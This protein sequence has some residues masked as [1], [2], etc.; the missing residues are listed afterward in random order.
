MTI[1]EAEVVQEAV[2]GQEVVK[3]KGPVVGLMG[4]VDQEV[5]SYPILPSTTLDQAGQG[6]NNNTR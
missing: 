2:V 6:L 1:Q 3:C 4:V 5:I